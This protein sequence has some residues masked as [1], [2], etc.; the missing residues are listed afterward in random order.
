M[1]EIQNESFQIDGIPIDKLYEILH[2]K[3]MVLFNRI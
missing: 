3:V 1:P 2:N